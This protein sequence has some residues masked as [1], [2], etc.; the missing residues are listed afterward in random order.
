[1]LKNN[2]E[3]QR[4]DANANKE[5]PLENWGPYLSERQWGTVREDYSEDGDAWNYFPHDQARSRAYLWGEDGIAGIS[6]Q[7]QDICFS[8]ALWNGHD[9]ILKER[10]FGLNNHE[11]NHGEDV[12]ELY[13]FLDNV[14]THFY[15]QYL[16]KYPQTVFPYHELLEK[17]K[18][19]G[20]NEPE[21]EIL[22][23]GIF[24]ENKYFDVCITYAKKDSEDILIQIDIT[25]RGSESAPITVLPTL[26]FYN[27]WQYGGLMQKPLISKLDDCSV[28]VK[29]ERAGEYFFYFD[30]GSDLLFTENET[31]NKKLFGTPN[32]SDV[33]KDAFHD[34]I[35]EN[36]GR[37][38]LRDRESGTKFSP[39]Y[40][41]NIAG[42]EKKSIYLRLANRKIKDPLS[43]SIESVFLERKKEADDFYF[44]V[45]PKNTLPELANIQRQ[46]FAGML[47][48]KQYYHYDVARW[49]DGKGNQAIRYHG[50]NYEWKNLKNQ[51]IISMPD[52]WEY[53]WY[54]SW[55]SAF[56]AISMAL[57]DPVFA[58]NQLVMLMREWYMDPE[59]QL[60]AYEWNFSAVNP[61]VHAFAALE[62]YQIEKK[63]TGT[64]DLYFLKKIF[65]KLIINF[66]WWVNRKDTNGNNI[67]EGGFLGLDNIGIFDRNMPLGNNVTLEQTDATSWMGM[68]ALNM[69][70]IALEIA[71]ADLSFEDTATK[72]YE[73][74]VIIAEA[75]NELHLWNEADHFFYDVLNTHGS[76]PFPLKIRS[77]VGLIPLFA[78]SI[79]DPECISK[80]KDFNKRVNWFNNYR[81]TN[82]KYLPSS[83][84]SADNDFLLSLVNKD[85]LVGLLKHF[86]DEN[87][88]L[89]PGGIRSLSKEY[90]GKPYTV[91]LG[92]IP[93]TI[94]YDPA[95]ATSGMFGGN[96]NWRGPVWF[97][98]NYLFIKALLKYSAFYGDSLQVEY[99]N[100]SGKMLNLQQVAQELI[101]RLI[102][103]F[104]SDNQ[105]DKP[106]FGKYNWFYKNENKDLLQFYEYFHG[107]TG[108]GLGAS[109][110]TGWTALIANLM[111][112][113][114]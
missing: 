25:N 48:N 15:M 44:S 4:L 108:S 14:P 97:P 12:K 89:S 21:F 105:G 114:S 26:W 96:S 65:Q 31:N 46:A 16:Y 50:R 9:P 10:L 42:G 51:D 43:E 38:F 57:I 70:D 2:A 41:Y 95:E 56:H 33:V 80:L 54:A 17:N 19:L 101:K 94:Q 35:I 40:N 7:M 112:M 98:L 85:K 68:Y 76:A 102:S 73:H 37:Q 111:S 39:V 45:F 106:M 11:G 59:G 92:D 28:H 100:G 107:D 5:V 91:V 84:R 110:Q 53:P 47:W 66:T 6:D 103:L 61:P 62:V 74:F 52:T 77:V 34:A 67:F 99:P 3:Q 78:V 113:Q 83:E 81:V 87:A 93:Y 64:G 109:H 49:L 88:F 71:T 86:L 63:K 23:T 75:L 55:D 82:K 69:M 24:N 32:N 30:E 22:D 27:R 60:P 29:H 8:V 18:A 79:I 1:M 58:K 36:K 104:T 13:Y 90:E 20:R 72:F